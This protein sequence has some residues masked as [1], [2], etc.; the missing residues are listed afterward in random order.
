MVSDQMVAGL[1]DKDIQEEILARDKTLPTFRSRYDFIEAYELEKL[2][3]SQLH[4]GD[5][6][7]SAAAK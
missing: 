4:V 6:S 2:A 1:Y 7:L 3:K 5:T